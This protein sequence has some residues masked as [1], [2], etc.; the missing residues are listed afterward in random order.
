MR[1]EEETL[2]FVFKEKKMASW[3]KKFDNTS[4]RMYRIY[5]SPCKPFYE[6]G[7]GLSGIAIDE[8]GQPQLATTLRIA[9]C[10]TN[11]PYCQQETDVYTN[12][13]KKAIRKLD[14]EKLR[15]LG[16]RIYKIDRIETTNDLNV[17]F[18]T[19]TTSDLDVHFNTYNYYDAM[20]QFT[21]YINNTTYANSTAYINC[22]PYM[23]ADSANFNLNSTSDRAE[24]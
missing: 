6:R 8:D 14:R 1:A 2:L 10:W 3:Y 22:N 23:V 5:Y 16:T 11:R 18:N 13:L 7:G 12:D 15:Y 9:E 20:R 24:E 17:C 21:T 4:Y 19:Y